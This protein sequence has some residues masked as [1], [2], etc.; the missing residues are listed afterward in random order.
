MIVMNPV[1]SYAP[2]TPA[3]TVAGVPKFL[4]GL[5][6]YGMVSLGGVMVLVSLYF[7]LALLMAGAQRQQETPGNSMATVAMLTL[8][9]PFLTA[10]AGGFVLIAIGVSV[11]LLASIAKHPGAP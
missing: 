6:Y 1:Y 11:R 10:L 7:L 2:L 9:A 4:I 8:M 3:A 5:C